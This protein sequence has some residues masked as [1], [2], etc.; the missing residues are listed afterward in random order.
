[1]ALEVVDEFLKFH[2][3]IHNDTLEKCMGVQVN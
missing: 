1:M 3:N 2:F